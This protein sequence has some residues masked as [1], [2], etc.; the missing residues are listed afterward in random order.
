MEKETEMER[1]IKVLSWLGLDLDLDLGLD[2]RMYV[3]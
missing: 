2:T 3:F 1:G